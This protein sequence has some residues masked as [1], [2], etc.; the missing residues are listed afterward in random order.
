MYNFSY[1]LTTKR[2]SYQ[3][4]QG[5]SRYGEAFTKR[6]LKGEGI[7]LIRIIKEKFTEF[8]ITE[9]RKRESRRD[10][11][12]NSI[13]FANTASI[14]IIAIDAFIAIVAF[15]VLMLCHQWINQL[16]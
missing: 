14:S 9:Y 7:R 2:E 6:L 16:K 4:E 15:I 5:K 10:A 12:R 11:L 3:N 13:W 1:L 8:D